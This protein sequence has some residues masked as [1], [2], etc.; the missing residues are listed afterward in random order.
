[1]TIRSAADA[2]RLGRAS[3][4]GK[5]SLSSP[6]A[7]L[8]CVRLTGLRVTG[9]ADLTGATFQWTNAENDE[10]AVSLRLEGAEV[11]GT[12]D[13]RKATI[14]GPADFSRAHVRDDLRLGG[15]TIQADPHAVQ[16]VRIAAATGPTEDS[17]VAWRPSDAAGHRAAL[18]MN[19]ISIG[20][21]LALNDGLSV[22]GE[23]RIVGAMIGGSIPLHESAFLNDGG[24][25]LVIM[26][27]TVAGS[28]AIHWREMSGRLVLDGTSVAAVVDNP[29]RWPKDISL[30][31]FEFKRFGPDQTKWRRWDSE[32]RIELLA[33]QRPFEIGPYQQFA[34]V[35]RSHGRAED[36]DRIVIAGRRQ[37]RK[38]AQNQTALRKGLAWLDDRLLGFGLRPG[39]V[40]Y[41][42]L[43]LIGML[44]I[45]LQMPGAT[46]AF[47]SADATGQIYRPD[48]PV[49]GFPALG[50]PNLVR[51]RTCGN[52]AVRCFSAPLLAI[53]TM[54]PLVD[55]GQRST[56]YPQRDAPYGTAYRLGLTIAT[57]LG[58]VLSSVAVVGFSRL[59]RSDS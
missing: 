54:V 5:L 6:F 31:G 26:H 19:G 36:A 15:A 47:R 12:L 30:L 53:D 27:C 29:T 50:G 8:G 38:R 44:T 21:D 28:I 20:G 11:G 32:N 41:V 3:I 52:G 37:S 39:R 33:R 35:F 17:T 40:V 10:N 9:S 58:W 45:A 49:G 46:L 16:R 56:W 51:D 7:A 13:L 55:L 2:L 59:T 24:D 34:E 1:M 48:G 23:I 25:A 14:L 22:R 4:G 42:L 18:V 43:A 57:L